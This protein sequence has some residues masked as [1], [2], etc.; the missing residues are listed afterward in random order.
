LGVFKEIELQGLMVS[1][2]VFGF[3]RMIPQ[4]EHLAERNKENFPDSGSVSR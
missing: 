4:R 2:A 3:N 1:S